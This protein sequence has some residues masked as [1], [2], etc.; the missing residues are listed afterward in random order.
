[1]I[2]SI[3]LLAGVCFVKLKFIYKDF[4]EFHTILVFVEMLLSPIRLILGIIKY[5]LVIFFHFETA[6][7]TDFIDGILP[8][9]LVYVLEVKSPSDSLDSSPLGNL[10]AQLFVLLPIAA[11]SS[12]CFY[13]LFIPSVLTKLFDI[14]IS[15]FVRILA[16]Y[17]LT[18][19]T[20][21]YV[22]LRKMESAVLY[23]D[24]TFVYKNRYI[25]KKVKFD[26]N[27]YHVNSSEAYECGWE[28]TS[29][30]NTWIMTGTYYLFYVLSPILVFLQAIG[31]VFAFISLFTRHI[32]FCFGNSDIE[33]VPLKGIQKVL[34]FL[35][36]FIIC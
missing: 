4:M 5:I 9:I 21:F 34:Y 20:M 15:L 32:Y 29:G 17:G 6:Y 2:F 28:K 14:E 26:G 30:G 36:C 13:A 7:G 11:L 19:I 35:F 27:R 8:K 12:F 25:D 18:I 3:I 22:N 16:M 33:D 10:F 24:S 31:V 1:M 23:W